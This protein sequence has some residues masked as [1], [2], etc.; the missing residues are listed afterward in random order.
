[1][2]SVLF[3]AGWDADVMTA[4]DADMEA[5]LAACA[6]W[7]TVLFVPPPAQMPLRLT[8]IVVLHDGAPAAS[9][10]LPAAEALLANCQAEII[11]LHV[12]GA[13]LPTE[14]GS[15]SAPRMADHRPI[16][17]AEWRHEFSRRFCLSSSGRTLRLEVALGPPSAS[18]VEAAQRLGADLMVLTWGGSLE[19]GRARTLR[20]LCLAS[21]CPLLIVKSQPVAADDRKRIAGS[22]VWPWLRSAEDRLM[23]A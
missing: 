17:L 9:R 5:V 8:R 23:P 7:G 10:A 1:M 20:R 4:K 19:S 11:V 16:D 14:V 21:P 22:V 6:K 13:S 15:L 3:V 18:I 12:A 2:K